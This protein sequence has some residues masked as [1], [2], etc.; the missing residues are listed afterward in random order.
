[1]CRIKLEI[2][3]EVIKAAAGNERS[4]AEI[5]FSAREPIDR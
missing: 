2:T 3:E 1:V 5:S 4:G